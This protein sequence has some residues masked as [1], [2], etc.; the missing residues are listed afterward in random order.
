MVESVQTVIQALKETSTFSNIANALEMQNVTKNHRSF[1]DELVTAHYAIIPTKKLLPQDKQDIE[2]AIYNL[3]VERFIANWMKPA[4]YSVREV[5]LVDAEENEFIGKENVLKEKGF[6][7]VLSNEEIEEGKKDSFSIPELHEGQT[8]PINRIFL[9]E[10]E[11]TKPTYHTEGSILKFME[12][13]GRNLIEDQELKEL[14]KGKRIGTPA[15]V[16]TFIPKLLQRG[17]VILEKRN[18]KTTSLGATFIDSF[19]VN[20]IKDPSFTAEM[21][22]NIQQIQNGQK[23][24]EE[25]TELTNR[26]ACSIVEQMRAIPETTLNQII[27]SRNKDLHIAKCTCGG[28]IIDKKAF[29]GCDQFPTCNI[30]FP[31]SLKGKHIPGKQIQR[32]LKEGS[33][34]L[35]KD[36]KTDEGKTFDAFIVYHEG[37]LQ[38]STKSCFL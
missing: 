27:V 28:T 35:I 9:K 30:T 20:E 23:T 2:V 38:F 16:E 6:L 29:Y 31:K 8:L 19:P 22:Y 18:I 15:T 21:E 7:S 17:Y 37:K 32:L 1:N 12:S 36:F 24:F 25:M 26:F 13:A 3:I 10:G 4:I 11:T 33:T 34:D 14:M 5:V